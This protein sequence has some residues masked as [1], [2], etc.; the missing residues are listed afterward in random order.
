MEDTL[1]ITRKDLQ[2]KLFTEIQRFKFETY[3]QA[4]LY[5][6]GQNENY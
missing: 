5:A 2:D 6:W 1:G 4:K 3:E